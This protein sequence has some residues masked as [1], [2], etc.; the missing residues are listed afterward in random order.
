MCELVKGVQQ[1][2][3]VLSPLH[4]G[5]VELE[6]KAMARKNKSARKPRMIPRAVWPHLSRYQHRDEDAKAA[7]EAPASKPKKAAAT[8]AKLL[9]FLHSI[10]IGGK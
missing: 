5:A 1:R 4:A 6:R 7:T 9:K 2:R 10:H 8:D 3:A